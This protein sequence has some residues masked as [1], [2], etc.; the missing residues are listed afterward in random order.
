MAAA[1][2]A[3][4]RGAKAGTGGD[5][6]R[7]RKH[8]E[9]SFEFFYLKKQLEV[10]VS[11]FDIFTIS[12]SMYNNDRCLVNASNP[13]RLTK[14][15]AKG[16]LEAKPAG[17]RGHTHKHRLLEPIPERHQERVYQRRAPRSPLPPP[18]AAA[19]PECARHKHKSRIRALYEVTLLLWFKET[20]RL[21]ACSIFLWR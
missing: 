11:Y 18:M 1:L 20:A 16:R 21:F 7:R 3:R 9:K 6:R 14:Q 17:T 13:Q 8:D 19:A 2:Q 12:Q 10:R 5:R 15:T 4:T